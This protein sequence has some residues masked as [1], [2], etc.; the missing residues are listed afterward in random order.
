MRIATI[1][2]SAMPSLTLFEIMWRLP[3]T[4]FSY[5]LVQAAVKNGVEGVSRPTKDKEAWERIMAIQKSLEERR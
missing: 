1:A 5:L 2:A 3:F 4:S